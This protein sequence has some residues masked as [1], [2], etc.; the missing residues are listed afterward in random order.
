MATFNNPKEQYFVVDGAAI[1]SRARFTYYDSGTENPKAIFADQ[2]KTIPIFHQQL[3]D[4]RGELPVIYFDGVARVIREDQ[5][6]SGTFI[7]RWDLDPVDGVGSASNF[8]Q[9]SPQVTYSAGNIVQDSNSDLQQSVANNNLNND[10]T[11]VPSA[12]WSP[13][14]GLTPINPYSETFFSGT[15]LAILGTNGQDQL[16]TP[17]GDG[18]ITYASFVAGG[19]N[20][21]G[22]IIDNSGGHTIDDVGSGIVW[23]D[24]D[25]PVFGTEKRLIVL[26][27]SN[28]VKY[29]KNGG[30]VL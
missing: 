30:V 4:D 27:F 24:E 9:W 8:Q 26:W 16:I 28:G 15:S 6:E 23:V 29:G 19:T 3:T 2:G 7:L 10:P 11:D 20:S 25:V 21:Q 5:P 13:L 1:A 17:T 12:F 14:L 22:I 18:S